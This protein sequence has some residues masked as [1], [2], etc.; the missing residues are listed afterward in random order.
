TSHLSCVLGK[1]PQPSFAFSLYRLA[2]AAKGQGPKILAKQDDSSEEEDDEVDLTPEELEKKRQFEMKRKM[3]YNEAQNIKLARQLI[4]KEMRGEAA[5]NDGEEEEE[6]EDDD[7]DDD[8]D[9]EMQDACNTGRMSKE[10]VPAPSD[11]LE[12][13]AHSLE[14]VCSG[15]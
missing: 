14:E 12:N 13:I 9:D 3:H 5:D 4:A 10:S 11:P 8:D 15:L 7:D 6:E 1:Q 2:A